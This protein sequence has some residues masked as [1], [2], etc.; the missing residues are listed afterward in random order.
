MCVHGIGRVCVH[1][2]QGVCAWC[3]GCVHLLVYKVCVFFCMHCVCRV[4][5]CMVCK[6]CMCMVCRV[7]LSA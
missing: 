2:M 5:V 3:V 4:Y 7:C 6:V 1:G